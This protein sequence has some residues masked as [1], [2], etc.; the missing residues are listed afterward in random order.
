MKAEDTVISLEGGDNESLHIQMRNILKQQAEISFKAGF[1]EGVKKTLTAADSTFGAM[2]KVERQKGIQEVV[3]WINAHLTVWPG[4]IPT[5][6][7]LS[8]EWQAKLK[9]W[10]IE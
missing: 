9:E 6:Q 3:D 5:M 7:A 10:G 4:G 8:K 2:L 1:D